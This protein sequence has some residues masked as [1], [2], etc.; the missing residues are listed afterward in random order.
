MGYARR[1]AVGKAT[2]VA[3][4]LSPGHHVLGVDTIVVLDQLILGKPVDR[5]DGLRMLSLLADSTHQVITALCLA[6]GELVQELQSVSEVTFAPIDD[7][8]RECYWD[9]G[10]GADKAGCYA[11]Q[12]YGA[13]FVSH[14]RG[15]HSGIMGLPI[16][17]TEQLL[18]QAGIHTWIHRST[19]AESDCHTQK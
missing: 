7:T 8:T 9:T 12:G 11:I 5:E 3:S 15:S 18:K 17:E 4:Q 14:I 10:E 19:A 2:H 16:Y 13:T 1:M 6:S